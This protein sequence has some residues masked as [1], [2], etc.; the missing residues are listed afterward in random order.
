MNH[1]P[2]FKC[3]PYNSLS[4]LLKVILPIRYGKALIF[5]LKFNW[6]NL[7]EKDPIW[8][9]N[10]FATTKES[11]WARFII[12]CGCNVFHMISSLRLMY[13]SPVI[14][15]INYCAGWSSKIFIIHFIH[16]LRFVTR[17]LQCL[18][19]VQ[20][21]SCAQANCIFSLQI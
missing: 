8:N 15:H 10:G 11:L 21:S 9:K 4:C 16:N 14:L 1:H 20:V 17:S 3:I 2:Y 5:F 6:L 18:Y 19:S 12:R 7:V 13:L